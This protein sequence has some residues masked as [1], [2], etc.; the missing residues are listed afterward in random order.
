MGLW[1]APF[2]SVSPQTVAGASHASDDGLTECLLNAPDVVNHASCFLRSNF[3]LLSSEMP[4][5][6]P[7]D[8]TLGALYIGI[9]FST[10]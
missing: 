9:L 10:M 3:A 5:L 4:S 1:R 6:I 7:L 8:N 2:L